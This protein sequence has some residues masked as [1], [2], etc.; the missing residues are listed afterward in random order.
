M[1]RLKHIVVGVDFSRFSQVALGQAIRI[2]RATQAKLHVLHVVRA[3]VV[4]DLKEAL[5]DTTD[6]FHGEVR[7]TALEHLGQFIADGNPEGVDVVSDV[8]IGSP[9]V[10][11]LRRVQD[12][13]ADLLIVGMKGS[14][15]RPGGAGTV[16]AKC[17][18]KAATRVL[19]VHENSPERF[20]SVV[21]CVDFSEA[22]GRV[23]EQAVRICLQNKA[24]LHVMHAFYP[25]WK[26][27]HYMAPTRQAS[28]DYQEQYR[29]QLVDRLHQLLKPFETEVSQL[30]VDCHLLEMSETHEA[31]LEF[32]ERT[33]ADLIV[34]GTRG[35]TGLKALLLGTTA[36]RIIRESPCSVLA[37]K[38]E[39]FE[40]KVD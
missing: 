38:P 1:D 13:S 4:D 21:A 14:T 29:Q 27:L 9:L 15:G 36:E 11:I 28:P 6:G 31:V 34:I 25:P 7:T 5:R 19:L 10:E 30:N 20:T 24:H 3:S 18:R 17:M 39:G 12:V 22:S 8:V 35:R 40:Y 2:A 23:V 26:V 33:S 16:A 37:V 32:K